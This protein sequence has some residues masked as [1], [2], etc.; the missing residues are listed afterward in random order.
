MWEE[1]MS[2]LAEAGSLTGSVTRKGD[3]GV[4]RTVKL[5]AA[6]GGVITDDEA[7]LKAGKA[8]GTLTDSV[9]GDN[10]AKKSR[11]GKE[12][13]GK[14]TVRALSVLLGITATKKRTGTADTVP[15]DNGA[16]S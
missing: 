6:P 3:D 4:T 7:W 15:S 12:A 13:S 2:E 5:D 16:H 11:N 10:G 14:Q 8:G 9:K 1:I